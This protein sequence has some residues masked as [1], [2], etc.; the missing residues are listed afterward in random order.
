MRLVGSNFSDR[1]VEQTAAASFKSWAAQDQ[2]TEHSPQGASWSAIAHH[3]ESTIYR[4][5]HSLLIFILI[6]VCKRFAWKCS[7][8][9]SMYEQLDPLE[10][11][12]FGMHVH[13][14]AN[15]DTYLQNFVFFQL[16]LQDFKRCIQCTDVMCI[17]FCLASLAQSVEHLLPIW[18]PGF[19][20]RPGTANTLTLSTAIG[21]T[22]NNMDK[23]FLYIHMQIFAK[24]HS[25][26]LIHIRLFNYFHVSCVVG[27]SLKTIPPGPIRSMSAVKNKSTVKDM[28][29]IKTRV[30]ASLTI[31]TP[32]GLDQDKLKNNYIVSML[33]Q[34]GSM[35]V[36]QILSTPVRIPLSSGST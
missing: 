17:C 26:Q 36:T 10:K 18:G 24:L 3:I 13:T 11:E 34:I 22:Y 32:V 9:N 23:T 30:A 19:K 7:C 29:A 4:D 25:L 35:S 31:L 14:F 1:L 5:V 2:R 15:I 21:T 27:Y 28:S 20:S 8:Q 16:H 6:S 12:S 33:T